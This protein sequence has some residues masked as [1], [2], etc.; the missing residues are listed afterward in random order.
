MENN[1]WKK[2]LAEV[3]QWLGNIQARAPNSPVIIVGTH[4]DT[5]SETFP[6]KKGKELQQKIR[7][8]L[9]AVADAEKM[10]LTKCLDYFQRMVAF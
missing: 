10:G 3:P 8:R 6:A 9:I 7:E 1:R 4:Y 5:V 2:G